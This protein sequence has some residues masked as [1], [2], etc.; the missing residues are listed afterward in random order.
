MEDLAFSAS[1]KRLE[2]ERQA[3][4]AAKKLEQEQEAAA[5]RRYAEQ[6]LHQREAL[7]KRRAAREAE[8]EHRAEA[9]RADARLTGG[10][11]WRRTY[12]C[13][14]EPRDGD[15]VRLPD[16]ALGELTGAGLLQD[17]TALTLELELVDADD[18]I[19]GV[20][21]DPRFLLPEEVEEDRLRVSA[22]ATHAGVL[23]FAA[24]D[25]RAGVPP[26]TMLS[27]VRGRPDVAA[28]LAAGELR[29]RCRA[30]K[31]PTPSESSCALR[32]VAEGFHHG[33]ADAAAVDLGA[34]LTREL[35]RGRH[36]CLTLGD[37]IAVGHNDRT[38]RLVVAA[39]RPE[40][41]LCIL[42]TDLSVDVLPPMA[43]EERRRKEQAQEQAD[44]E[45]QDE[46]H[47]RACDARRALAA[48]TLPAD[49]AVVRVRLRFRDG[50]RSEATCQTTESARVLALFVDA[51]I[52]NMAKFPGDAR[53]WRLVSSYPRL[54][55][56][57]DAL[58]GTVADV[59]LVD[60]GGGAVALLVE[61]IANDMA[62]AD[63]ESPKHSTE[64][65]WAR[66]AGFADAE[67][68]RERN[69][70]RDDGEV[71]LDEATL[72][73]AE[74]RDLTGD[75]KAAQFR[76]LVKRG[77]DHRLAAHAAQHYSSQLA[78]L[79][80]MGFGADVALA[81][82]LLDKYNG[83]LLR[84]VNA[85]SDAREADPPPARPAPVARA[86]DPAVQQ[87]ARVAAVFARH[88]AAGLPPNEAAVAA[89]RE[90]SGN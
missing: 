17:A 3:R 61:P 19:S 52:D 81:V 71:A 88:V 56:E 8:E 51:H 89:L 31:L 20:P 45:L 32:P 34:V 60:A 82:S 53:D 44:Q 14:A 1:S 2:R 24:P 72:I 48:R 9:A 69:A 80:Q 90:V 54:A 64:D 59:G 79:D 77:L 7:V 35:G 39:L 36:C 25:G 73:E 47:G 74:R 13:L 75:L 58:H 85:L 16:A 30:V 38:V 41:A 37:W 18:G 43:V 33:G 70:R 28:R 5:A 40:R 87:Q 76:D 26:K 29:V 4:I 49:G 12:R 10:L 68:A 46:R 50:S 84:V 66:A 15:R 65:V 55:L 62:V 27:L 57:R 86:A 11:T 78:E 63:P 83:R 22:T 23:D 21:H 42:S 6:Q 67:A